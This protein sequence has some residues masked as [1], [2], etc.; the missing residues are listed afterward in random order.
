MARSWS[1]MGSCRPVRSCA[2]G[3]TA[4]NLIDVSNAWARYG[5]WRRSRDCPARLMEAD[6]RQAKAAIYGLNRAGGRTRN[7]RE[8]WIIQALVRGA[9]T[10]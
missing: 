10:A 3:R 9:K 4:T 6:E 1:A 8:A 7:W 5:D 2:G